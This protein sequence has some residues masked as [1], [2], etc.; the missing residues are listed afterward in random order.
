M[1]IEFSEAEIYKVIFECDFLVLDD[2]GVERHTAWTESVLYTI[3]NK[4]YM[5]KRLI[6]LSTNLSM[7]ELHTTTGTR[8]CDRLVEMCMC[9]TCKDKS[10]RTIKTKQRSDAN[11]GL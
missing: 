6:M 10:Y 9:I 2:I 4:R 1:E 11:G 5:T 3:V 8:T 7:Q